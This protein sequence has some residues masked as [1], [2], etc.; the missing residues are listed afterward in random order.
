MGSKGD[1]EGKKICVCECN[2][3]ATTERSSSGDI[4][5]VIVLN[6]IPFSSSKKEK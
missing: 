1:R 5:I 3:E 6:E 4:R 2:E